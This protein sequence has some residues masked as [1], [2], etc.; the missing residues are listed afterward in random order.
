MISGKGQFF[1]KGLKGI[2][3]PALEDPGYAFFVPGIGIIRCRGRGSCQNH[4]LPR[5]I[6]SAGNM[7]DPA[8]NMHPPG[9]GLTSIAAVKFSIASRILGCLDTGETEVIHR[10]RELRVQGDGLF[11]RR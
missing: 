8:G 11:K 3:V 7:R 5:G 1:C 6:F 4:R 10:I 2:F 9:L